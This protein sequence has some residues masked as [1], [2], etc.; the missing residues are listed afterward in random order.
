MENQNRPIVDQPASVW[1]SMTE[2]TVAHYRGVLPHLFHI[3]SRYLEC[4]YRNPRRPVKKYAPR[5]P[6][7]SSR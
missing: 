7:R 3:L 6:G 2:F 5:S 1:H 4:E